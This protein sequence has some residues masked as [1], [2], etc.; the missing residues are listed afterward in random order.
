MLRIPLNDFFVNNEYELSPGLYELNV[1]EDSLYMVNFMF[2]D[3]FARYGINPELIEVKV[4]GNSLF[5][6]D[7]EVKTT[8]SDLTKGIKIHCKNNDIIMLNIA[9]TLQHENNLEDSFTF[10]FPVKIPAN[11]KMQVSAE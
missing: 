6:E 3:V 9:F 2:A 8:L 10:Q 11:L 1:T 7:K 5:F 4:S